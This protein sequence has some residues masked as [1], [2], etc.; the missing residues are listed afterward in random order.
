MKGLTLVLA[1][2]IGTFFDT[3]VIQE[4]IGACDVVARPLQVLD[5]SLIV[6]GLLASGWVHE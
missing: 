1:P 5:G 4:F 3:G 2:A 6:Q